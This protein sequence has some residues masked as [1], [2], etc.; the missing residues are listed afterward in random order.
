MSPA[1]FFKKTQKVDLRAELEARIFMELLEETGVISFCCNS[2]LCERIPA[3]FQM[4]RHLYSCAMKA[5]DEHWDRSRL[6]RN[7]TFFMH[8]KLW[9]GLTWKSGKRYLTTMSNHF[10][11]IKEK[12]SFAVEMTDYTHLLAMMTL[13]KSNKRWFLFPSF[14]FFHAHTPPVTQTS[15]LLWNG[16][17]QTV[18]YPGR[19]C[20]PTGRKQ[21]NQCHSR[22]WWDCAPG[23]GIDL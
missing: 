20:F 21:F 11:R 6:C 2:F 3:S 17:K 7:N 4:R 8:L 5:N 16:I 23:A 15:F 13:F 9:R 1:S 10:K 19:N 14:F 12:K 18:L 22:L